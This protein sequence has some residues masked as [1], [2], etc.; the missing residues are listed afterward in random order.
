MD[1]NGVGGDGMDGN[2]VGGKGGINGVDAIAGLWRARELPSCQGVAAGINT[3]YRALDDVLADGGWPPGGLVELLLEDCGIGELRLLTPAL[4]ALTSAD[5][6][7]AW[8]NPPHVPYA[9]A[10]EAVGIDPARVLLVKAQGQ[11]EA[12]WALEQAC[13]SGACSAVLGWVDSR[14]QFTEIRRLQFAAKHGRTWASL[15]R[16]VAATRQ[17]SA[18]ELRLRLNAL[19]ENRLKIDVVKRRGGWPLAGIELPLDASPGLSSGIEPTLRCRR[20]NEALGRWRRA[21]GASA[22]GT[23]AASASMRAAKPAMPQEIA[24]VAE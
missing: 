6:F 14:L 19:T 20:L 24:K 15:F 8:V 18:A 22:S 10:L 17:A 13:K 4:A 2:G 5:R 23:T 9:P 11:A 7:I 3:G 21:R 12:L 1:G 16:P